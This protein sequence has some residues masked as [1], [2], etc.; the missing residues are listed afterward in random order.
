MHKNFLNKKS[1]STN[2]QKKVMYD[3]S[4]KNTIESAW[5]QKSATTRKHYDTFTDWLK[6]HT[7]R[8]HWE[9]W[10]QTERSRA[11]PAPAPWAAPKAAN[12]R[13]RMVRRNGISVKIGT[14]KILQ[15]RNHSHHITTLVWHHIEP[16]NSARKHDNSNHNATK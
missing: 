12:I 15:L 7:G 10:G 8:K 1:N 2:V 6:N 4:Q 16:L 5:G 3:S 13:W 14:A 11:P 9:V